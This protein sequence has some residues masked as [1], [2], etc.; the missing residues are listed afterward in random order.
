MDILSIILI[1]VGLAMDCFAVSVSKGLASQHQPHWKSAMLMAFF[2]GLYQGG[3]PLL[4]F[5]AGV[6]F[7]DFF[8]KWSHWIALILLSFIGG[9]MLWDSLK[10]KTETEA[11]KPVFTIMEMQLLAIATSIDALATGVLFI[12]VPERI[13][14]AV[15]IIAFVSL[16]FSITGYAIGYVFGHRFRF[17]ST[18]LGGIILIG[19]GLKIF[20]EHYI[21]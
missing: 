2:F 17:N 3:M 21:Q 6:R 4:S 18:L 19:I 1:A 20:I 10:K 15:S 9:K 11:E 8:D 14:L 12:P 16:A 13:W 7:A 5:Y